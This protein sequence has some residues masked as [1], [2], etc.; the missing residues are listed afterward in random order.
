[1]ADISD[2]PVDHY[3][4]FLPHAGEA[5]K[6]PAGRP[7]LIAIGVAV[8]L[9]AIAVAGFAVGHPTFGVAVTL[10]AAALLIFGFGWIYSQRTR[11]IREER[12][13]LDEHGTPPP[14]A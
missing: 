11:V 12:Q 1:M 8:F 7:G 9:I 6:N 4:T 13:W 14:G 3:R 10:M 5:I 2:D